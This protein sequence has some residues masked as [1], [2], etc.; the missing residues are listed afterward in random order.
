MSWSESSDI[1]LYIYLLF[2]SPICQY[3]VCVIKWYIFIPEKAIFPQ[4]ICLQVPN[5]QKKQHISGHSSVWISFNASFHHCYGHIR[6]RQKSGVNQSPYL[7]QRLPILVFIQL[8]CI[9]K[10]SHAGFWGIFEKQVATCSVMMTPSSVD[11]MLPTPDDM[12]PSCDII[13]PSG[14]TPSCE[15]IVPSWEMTPSPA[16]CSVISPSSTPAS[17]EYS[18]LCTIVVYWPSSCWM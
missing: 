16:I 17:S 2:G 4:Y 5:A 12:I 9:N 7:F 6:A 10:E 15:M 11:T 1:H 18:G 14:M 13:A 3:Q 8:K